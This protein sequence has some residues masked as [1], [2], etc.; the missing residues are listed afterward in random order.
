MKIYAIRDRLIDY[1]MTPFCADSDGQVLTSLA[2]KIND[3]RSLDAI[4]Q[5]PHH[6]ELWSLGEV[7]ENDGIIIPK[8]EFLADCSSLVRSSV[9]EAGRPSQAEREGLA[10]AGQ[11]TPSRTRSPASAEAGASEGEARPAAESPQGAR[12]ELG[13]VPG[14]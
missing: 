8:R 1:Y 14:H 11:A 9:R 13:G 6:F 10:P 4:T 7:T 12:A 5:T 3:A 2:N